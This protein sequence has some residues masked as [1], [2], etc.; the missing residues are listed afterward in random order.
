[1][2]KSSELYREIC[3]KILEAIV[4]KPEDIE[5]TIEETDGNYNVSVKVAKEDMGR[6]IGKGGK[7]IKAIRNLLKIRAIKAGERVNITL[8]E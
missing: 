4:S 8:V 3:H 2:K 1:M 6:V 5:V 7:I